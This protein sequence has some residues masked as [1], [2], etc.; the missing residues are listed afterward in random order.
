M[1]ITGI[2]ESKNTQEILDTIKYFLGVG[3]KKLALQSMTIGLKIYKS[4]RITVQR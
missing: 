1:H 4:G 2:V 3:N